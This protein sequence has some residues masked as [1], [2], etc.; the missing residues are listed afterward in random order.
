VSGILRHGIRATL[1]LAHADAS[2]AK[3]DVHIDDGDGPVARGSV[4]VVLAGEATFVVDLSPAQPSTTTD[5]ALGLARQCA[6]SARGDGLWPRTVRR[7]RDL[8]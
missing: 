8:G 4:S 2:Q 3:Y 7:W 5:Y 1:Q 6:S